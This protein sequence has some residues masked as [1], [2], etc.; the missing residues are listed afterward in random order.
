MEELM[1][2]SAPPIQVAALLAMMRVR[3]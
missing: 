1:D 2:G 3:G